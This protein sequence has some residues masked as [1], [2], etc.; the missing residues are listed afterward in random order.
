MLGKENLYKILVDPNAEKFYTHYQRLMSIRLQFQGIEIPGLKK[1][2]VFMPMCHHASHA[3]AKAFSVDVVDGEKVFLTKSRT[4]IFGRLITGRVS[5]YA[6]SWNVIELTPDKQLV[7]DIIP[8]ETCSMVPIV[9]EYPHP[10]YTQPRDGVAKRCIS[11]L[12]L[13]PQ[14]QEI[15]ELLAEEFRR[16]TD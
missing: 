2:E 10:A 16:I 1:G 12:I 9:V 5:R 7:L 4:W 14:H 11:E 8:D 13:Q 3:Y 6:H 15:I